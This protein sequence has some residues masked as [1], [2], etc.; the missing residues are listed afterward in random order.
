M[1][2]SPLDRLRTLA[3]Q[4]GLAEHYG[5]VAG[6]LADLAPDGRPADLIR[7]GTLLK[8]LDPDRIRE[9]HP[10]TEVVSLA[11]TGWSTLDGLVAPLTAELARHGWVFRPRLSDFAAYRKDLGDT[12][13]PLYTE[14]FE[15]VLCLLDAQAVFDRLPGPWTASDVEKAASEFGTELE[16]LTERFLTE[17]S[18]RLVLNTIVLPRSLS[19]QFVD[20]AT[21]CQIGV[22]W[23]ELNIRLLKL[24]ARSD[25]VAVID[26]EQLV[27]ASG[28][29]SDARMAQYAKARFSDEL[30]AAYAREVTHL[31]RAFRG[32]SKKVLA[33][34]LDN[35][36]WDGVLGDDGPDRVAAAS[37]LRGEAF[38]AFQRVV[39]QLASQGVLLAV[40]SKN[41]DDLVSQVLSEHSDM[42]LRQSDFAKVVANWQPKDANLRLIAEALDLGLDS[43]VFVDDSPAECGLV[44]SSLPQVAVVRLDDEPAL[45]VERLLTDDWF[46]T[47]RLTDEDRR[48]SESYRHLAGR[49][50]L[51]D[52]VG[53]AESYLQELGVTVSVSRGK[54]FET[55]RLSQLTLRTNQFNLTGERL[56]SADVTAWCED[57]EGLV[58]SVR[59][60]DRFG[61]NGLIGAVFARRQD[62][63]LHIHNM[64]LSCRV[65]DR[66]VE[67]AAMASLLTYARAQGHTAVTGTYRATERNRRFADFYPSLGFVRSGGNEASAEFR[68][69]LEELP[70]VP[71]HIQLSTDLK[72]P[73]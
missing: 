6:I 27:A 48:R 10:E 51:R 3:A 19:H 72:E 41:D 8:R 18:G 60:A 29:L 43:F 4:G 62:A 30:L 46:A 39:R 64:L 61:D 5:S 28:S 38:G 50:K 14:N 2:A 70:G 55:E 1:T 56:S 67:A 35:T 58:L 54:G 24:A 31:I 52:A 15:A 69:S 36:L 13:S 65:F 42:T 49:Q 45:H 66:G 32:R 11:V 44:S 47:L 73:S 12:A 9:H 68:H 7:A 22:N 34:D 37:T 57:P 16:E 20:H 23:R 25:R 63:T 21:R 33:V 26:M 59:S 17:G 53:S 71:G 40:C